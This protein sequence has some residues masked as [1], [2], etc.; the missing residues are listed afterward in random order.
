MSQDDVPR[1]DGL[2]APNRVPTRGVAF[3]ALVMAAIALM[4]SFGSFP[5]GSVTKPD[6]SLSEPPAQM[7]TPPT[8][9]DLADVELRL[10]RLEQVLEVV[11]S[12]QERLVDALAVRQAEAETAEARPTPR[13]AALNEPGTIRRPGLD[14]SVLVEAGFSESDARALRDAYETLQMEQLY[15]RD[16]AA[17]EGWNLGDRL[18]EE[19]AAL[20]EREEALADD[21]GDEAYDWVLYATGRPNRVTVRDVFAESPAANAGL[22]EGDVLVRYD[23][24]RVRS[25]IELRNATTEGVAGEWVDVEILRAGKRERLRLPRG[26]LGILLD[27]SSSEPTSS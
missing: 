11:R 16:R 9:K 24:R 27:V 5:A 15:L 2:E 10:Q 7:A 12:E 21:Y 25:S 26:P 13:D 1:R 14:E 4:I 20:A 19:L 22:A 8:E 3:F 18:G 23:D 6:A 17:R